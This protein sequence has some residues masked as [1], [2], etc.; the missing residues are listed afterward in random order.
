MSK[1][2]FQLLLTIFNPPL[3]MLRTGKFGTFTG[4]K[5]IAHDK[6]SL[7]FVLCVAAAHLQIFYVKIFFFFIWFQMISL[8]NTRTTR[9]T[10]RG[11]TQ[12]KR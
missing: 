6:I 2:S 10:P 4:P 11:T 1:I 3:G 7:H 9:A 5:N 8:S 12:V